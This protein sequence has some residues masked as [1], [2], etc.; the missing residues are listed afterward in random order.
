M[1]SR[2]WDTQ[3]ILYLPVEILVKS[4]PCPSSL[5]GHLC[6]GLA[7]FKGQCWDAHRVLGS[8]P[9]T[10]DTRRIPGGMAGAEDASRVP[11]RLLAVGDGSGMSTGYWNDHW[12]PGCPLGIPGGCQCP[13]VPRCPE[14]GRCSQGTAMSARCRCRCRAAAGLWCHL[15]G[16]RLPVAPVWRGER[17]APAHG[18]PGAAA[19]LGAPGL[20]PGWGLRARVQVSAPTPLFRSATPPWPV[21]PVFPSSAAS[22]RH[23]VPVLSLLG[24][25]GAFGKGLSEKLMS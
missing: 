11:G 9:G 15:V 5:E 7:G 25:A 24:R 8:L 2:C 22:Q 16:C 20:Q 10:G 6:T 14:D 3:D 23:R 1:P 19:A 12:V 4:K 13:R 18:S 17:A 21:L